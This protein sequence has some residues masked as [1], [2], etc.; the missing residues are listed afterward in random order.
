LLRG[1]EGRQIASV[2]VDEDREHS[3]PYGG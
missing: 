1:G 2:A 3:Q